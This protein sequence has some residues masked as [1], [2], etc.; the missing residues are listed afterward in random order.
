MT[1]QIATILGFLAAICSTISFAPQAWKIIRSRR[2]KD[3][4]AK[5]YIVTVL[6]FALWLAYGILLAQWPLMLSN[7]ICLLLSGFI[8]VM[9]L[10]PQRLKEEIADTVDPTT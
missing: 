9:K 3:I 8:L 10:S 5:M 4:S 1:P 6:G 7:G 2:T